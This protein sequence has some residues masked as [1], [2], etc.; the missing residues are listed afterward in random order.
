MT[1]RG[2]NKGGQLVKLA[3]FTT[4]GLLLMWIL[5]STLL[6][7]TNGAPVATSLSSPT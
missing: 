5:G 1:A 4:V 7:A 2:V 3:I 6:N